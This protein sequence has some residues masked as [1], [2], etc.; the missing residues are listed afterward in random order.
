MKRAGINM[1]RTGI[2]TG[3][4][5]VMFNDGIASEEILRAIDGLFMIAKKYDI[6]ICFNFFAFTP[7]TWEGVNP[8]LDPRSVNAQKR[9]ILSIV[10]RHK[11]SKGVSWDLINEPS[12]CHKDSLWAPVPNGDK[13]EIKE[14]QAYLKNRHKNIEK[15]QER[16]NVSADEMPSF[17]SATLP[18]RQDFAQDIQ[19]TQPFHSLK[20]VDYIL[21][22]QYVLVKWE[23]EMVKAIRSA[24][25]GQL[26]TVGQDEGL[27]AKRPSPFFYQEGVDYTTCHSWWLND[28]LYWD[29]IFSKTP[30]KPNLIQ[31][32]GIMYVQTADSSARRTEAELRDMLERKYA[33][34]F[35][36][37]NAGAVHW[38]WNTN[39]YMDSVNEV[40]IG[41]VRADGTQKLE[42]D[43]S[44]DY[45]S[46]ISAAGYLFKE[47][48]SEDVSIIFP[49]SNNFSSRDYASPATKKAV[50]IFGYDL[51]VP[52]K[53]YGEYHLDSLGADKLIVV[54][55][56]RTLSDDAW[57]ILM[58]RVK[59]GSNLL[60]TGP[61]NYD[62]YYDY[63]DRTSIFGIKA[64]LSGGK[65][66]ESIVIDGK[67]YRVSFGGDKIAW[68]DKETPE[69]CDTPEVKIIKYG[70]GSIIWSGIPV[71]VGDNI[72][73]AVSLY[74]FAVNYAQVKPDFEWIAGK[75]PG[76]LGKKLRFEVGSVYVFVSEYAYDDD[77]KITDAESDKTYSFTVPANRAALFAIDKR[78]DI[79]K[80]YRDIVIDIS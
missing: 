39:I 79:V 29:G 26:V 3:Y 64:V 38:I 2:W 18:S 49:Y 51:N 72:D 6:Y 62:E 46:F 60:I 30:D 77:I 48:K 34:A 71:E 27:A 76:I 61:L 20:T 54:P 70:K 35:A 31:E 19:F 4:R 41:A 52:V 8:Y 42:A 74:E 32:T 65:R 57:N 21:F 10:S 1:V 12:L 16:W 25:S 55:A 24:R 36:A 43:V 23:K 58:D 50:R 45:G 22:T 73:A 68:V 9:Y 59:S 17:E 5:T 63:V 78:G 69:G 56:P 66:E 15:L 37:D 47:R 7:E 67:T 14:W 80:S 75:N 28:D 13:M 44:Y 53:A 11:S 33:L 40:N